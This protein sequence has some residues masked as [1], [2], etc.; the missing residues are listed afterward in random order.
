M[1][2]LNNTSWQSGDKLWWVSKRNT[3]DKGWNDGVFVSICEDS[4]EYIMV[5]EGS[6]VKP[7]RY[8]KSMWKTPGT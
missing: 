5:L 3:E 2:P 4:D 6:M 8:R 1:Y 7:T